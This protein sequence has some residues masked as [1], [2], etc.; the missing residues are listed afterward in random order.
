MGILRTFLA[1]C[2]F[3]ENAGAPI[4]GVRSGFLVRVQELQL[5]AAGLTLQHAYDDLA[6]RTDEL[7]AWARSIGT[8]DELPPP[9]TAKREADAL[10]SVVGR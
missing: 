2:V 9:G 1:L 7:L 4:V 8:L 10:C 6:R 5:T 3:V